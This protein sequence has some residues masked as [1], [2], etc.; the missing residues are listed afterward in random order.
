MRKRNKVREAIISI[1]L[2]SAIGA[3]AALAFTLT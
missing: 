1:V 2:T 3:L